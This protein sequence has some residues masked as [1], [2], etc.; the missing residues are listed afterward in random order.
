MWYKKIRLIS[1]LVVLTGAISCTN[2]NPFA[3][4]DNVK[5]PFDYIFSEGK[6]YIKLE[7]L[8]S[9]KEASKTLPDH[10]QYLKK[11]MLA[12]TLSSI[13]FKKKGMRGWSRGQNVFQESELL[14]LTSHITGAFT[15]ASP[16]QY[17][18]VNSNYKR[19]IKLSKSEV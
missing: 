4:K 13:Y 1:L 3:L 12:S 15:R 14:K 10:P 18:L 16:S 11:D 7:K 6:T 2:S 19:G 9:T 17:I 5:D 8:K